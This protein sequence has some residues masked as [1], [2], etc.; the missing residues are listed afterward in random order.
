MP[1][2]NRL[3]EDALRGGDRIYA[4]IL[5]LFGYLI[6]GAMAVDP[7]GWD[8][9]VFNVVRRLP[10]TPYSWAAML[11]IASTVYTAG[12]V[13]SELSRRRGAMIIT[14]A[15]MCAAW[16]LAMTLAISR[17]VY[18][19]PDRITDIWP[20]VCL[21][22]TCIYAHR[23]IVYANAFTGDRWNT[24]P[25]QLWSVTMIMIASLGGII[26]GVAPSSV[27]T[28]VER[29]VALQLALVNFMGAAVV[30][31]GLHL[32][33]KDVG[34]NLEL[35]GGFSLVATLGWYC[36][37]VLQH[38]LLAST[39]L[40]FA[41]IEAATFAT[42]HRSI[43]ILT[44]KWAENRGRPRLASRMSQALNAERIVVVEPESEPATRRQPRHERR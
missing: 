42:L 43:Q 24:N 5:I 38:Q 44:K 35:S 37:S 28:E 34:L 10:Y 13:M 9:P 23:M 41:A 16:W 25:Y 31:Y 32:K 30:M 8:D 2:L 6:A 17:M 14:G 36:T 21:L 1:I 15:T 27:F 12:E 4:W 40:G 22:I 19:M 29:P 7:N 18:V 39:T 20:L 11:A 33:N 26:I 3:P